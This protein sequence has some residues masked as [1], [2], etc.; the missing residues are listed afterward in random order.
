MSFHIATRM[1]PFEGVY[2]RAPAMVHNYEHGTTTIA[3]VKH[4]LKK[5]DELLKLLKEN[6][7]IAQHR[8]KLNEYWH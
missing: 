2:G 7:V 3:Q 5:R 6:L 1:T 8:M 4:S